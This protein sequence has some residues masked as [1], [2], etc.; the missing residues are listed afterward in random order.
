MDD[1]MDVK[2]VLAITMNVL[3]GI[4]IPVELAQQV[5]MPVLGA[6]GNIR[7]CLEA[8][9]NSECGIRNAELKADAPEGGGEA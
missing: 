8:L 4:Q 9:D 5:G 7:L 6:M 1:K 3:R 2:Q